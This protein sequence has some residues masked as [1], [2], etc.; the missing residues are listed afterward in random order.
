M[1]PYDFIIIGAGM[2]GASAAY[3]LAAEARV[4]VLEAEDHPGFHA[5]GRSAAFYSETYGN[6]LIRA[7]TSAA[8][9]FFENPPAAFFTS[10]LLA[11]SGALFIG[12]KDQR[13]AVEQYVEE[14]A[15]PDCEVHLETA[16]FARAKC[17]VLRESYVDSCAWEPRSEAIDV[18]ALLQ[19][20]LKG[21]RHRGA[22]IL[23]RHPTT[24]L[25]RQG[26]MWQ[27]T[28]GGSEFQAPVVLNAAGAWADK[29]A[30]M[31]GLDPKG[32]IPKRRSMAVIDGPADLTP[33]GW[34]LVI[35]VDEDFYFKPD[36]RRLWL[37]P[38]DE[39]PSEPCDAWADDMDIAY[40]VERF[41]QATTLKV[42][43]VHNTW[44]GLRTFAPD[45]SPL[46][47]FDPGGEGFFWLAGQGGY[48][49]Q[50]SPTMARIAAS[51]ATGKTLPTDLTGIDL[52]ALSPGRFDRF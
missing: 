18:A 52:G 17:P 13:R 49:I 24:A 3:E 46:V 2:A 47:G 4:L 43:R 19:G 27:I 39:T 6:S 28:A 14:T 12:R 40:A 11:P 35:D 7:I 32:L 16:A 5:T 20:F 26:G 9:P 48:G 41:E 38:A 42:T 50:T 36:G 23:T 51:L 25:A 15:S 33:H 30:Q 21:A 22:E 37:S 1:T 31:A 44:A 45:K 29:I 8:R 34:P 10:P